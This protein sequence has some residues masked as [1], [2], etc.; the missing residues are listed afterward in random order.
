MILN[1]KKF[2]NLCHIILDFCRLYYAQETASILMS[3]SA[4]R[5]CSQMHQVEGMTGAVINK[6]SATFTSLCVCLY[7]A[8]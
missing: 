2:S 1:F 5:K 4:L 6:P 8:V 7:I 3:E